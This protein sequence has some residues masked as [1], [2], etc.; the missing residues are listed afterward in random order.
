MKQA[1]RT[2][3]PVPEV[4]LATSKEDCVKWCATLPPEKKLFGFSIEK[5][6]ASPNVFLLKLAGRDTVLLIPVSSKLPLPS[7]IQA[8]LKDKD[9]I[10]AGISNVGKDLE[11]LIA[12]GVLSSSYKYIDLNSQ[13]ESNFD[14]IQNG[15]FDVGYYMLVKLGHTAPGATLQNRFAQH[16]VRSLCDQLGFEYKS[17]NQT[18]PPHQQRDQNSPQPNT[19]AAAALSRDPT[20]LSKVIR[21]KNILTTLKLKHV[22]LSARENPQ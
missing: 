3:P 8:I 16:D 18:S 7:C 6:T 14:A 15:Y 12:I 9:N 10:K 17:S 19:S 21:H 4:I 22:Q 1:A 20:K 5:L 11:L 13:N 2:F